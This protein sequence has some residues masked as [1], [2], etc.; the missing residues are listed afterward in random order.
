MALFTEA[1]LRSS[2]RMQ[3][4]AATTTVARSVLLNESR[5]SATTATFDIFLSHSYLDAQI[6]LGLKAQLEDLGHT[7]YVDWLVDTDL[8]RDKVDKGTA[9]R[10]RTRMN[11]SR[12][13]FYA[14]TANA[15][16]SKWMPWECGYMDANKHRVAIC[17]IAKT[18]KTYSFSGQEYLGLYPYAMKAKKSNSNEDALWIHEAVKKYVI[19]DAWLDGKEPRER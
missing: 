15:G 18:E 8:S 11:A 1:A 10:L 5:A 17:P 14:T 2:A 7:V 3:K 19:F 4:S 16:N 13:L 9:A 6:I 12:C